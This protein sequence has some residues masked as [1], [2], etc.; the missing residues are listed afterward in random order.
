M[1]KAIGAKY[2]L[3]T[4]GVGENKQPAAEINLIIE[5][6]YYEPSDDPEY[7]MEMERKLRHHQYTFT[8]TANQ[9]E[10]LGKQLIGISNDSRNKLFR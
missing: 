9:L 4:I 1:K 10:A 2:E 7:D 3:L 8:N 6:P 5:E